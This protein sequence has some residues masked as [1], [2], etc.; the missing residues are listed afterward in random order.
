MLWETATK[1]SLILKYVLAAHQPSVKA[2]S[3]SS[4]IDVTSK[5]YDAIISDRLKS[6]FEELTPE[7][8]CE[9]RPDL[10]NTLNSTTSS[11]E[12]SISAGSS[13]FFHSESVVQLDFQYFELLPIAIYQ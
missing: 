6:C 9:P 12:V 1:Y 8:V 7:E 4:E 2:C 10:N 13:Y 11:A 3:G 5:L